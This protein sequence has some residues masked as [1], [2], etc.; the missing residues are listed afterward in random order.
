[1]AHDKHNKQRDFGNTRTDRAKDSMK[2]GAEGDG[3]KERKHPM[4]LPYGYYPVIGSAMSD[5]DADDFAS[6]SSPAP[7]SAVTGP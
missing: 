7:S 2:S 3:M 6:T 5:N 4:P 1:M